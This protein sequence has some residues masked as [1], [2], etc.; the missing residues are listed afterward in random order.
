MDI[1]KKMRL[2]RSLAINKVRPST[3]FVRVLPTDY[4]NLNCSYCWQH[5][6]DKHQMTPAL[7]RDCL[8]NAVRLDAGLVSFLG[9]EPTLWPHLLDAIRQCTRKHL[10]T[11]LTTNG[12]T[13]NAGS[14]NRLAEAG[15]DLLNISV[16]GLQ[17]TAQSRKCSI[18]RP[19]LLDAIRDVMSRTRLRVRMNAVICKNNWPL[20]RELLDVSASCRI[21]L[22]LGFVVQRSP[23]EFE[24]TIHFRNSDLDLI[25]SIT[26]QVIEAKRRGVRIIDPEAY[27]QGYT[28]FLARERF[29][30]CNYATRRGWINIDPHGWIRDCTKKF[31]R[32]HYRFPDLT[33]DQIPE[34][35]A[36][37]AAGVE[38]CNRD[39]YSNCA[40]DG[41]Y[42]ARHKFQFLM[43][44][45]T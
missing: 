41:A 1:A 35:R 34:V 3:P 15:L 11:D 26:K 40:F 5:T 29:W 7:F 30:L 19:G 44:G 27:F 2:L 37:L 42:F 16:D 6:A 36:K 22:S 17:E 4:C 33:R 18:A 12:S 45:I 39:C 20:I 9:G 25:R 13:L 38:K 10:C 23:F 21:P 14:L 28:R 32:I 43:S 8:D 31:S 24:S